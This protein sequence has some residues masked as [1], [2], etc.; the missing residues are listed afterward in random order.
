M[1]N[2]ASV[3]AGLDS[4]QRAMTLLK[5]EAQTLPL[6]GRLK[7]FVKNIDPA[8]ATRYAE[9]VDAPEQA[10]I[11]ILRLDTPWVPVK[12]K[13][14]FAQGFHHGDL[15]FKDKARAEILT[16]CKTVPTIVALYLDP[17]IGAAAKA[18]IGEYGASDT[19]VL[20][21]VFGK[22]GPEGKLPFELPDSMEAVRNQKSD[23]P[24]DS[25]NPLYPFGFGLSY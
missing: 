11:A 5:N 18:L 15:D 13:N 1:G 12:T 3:A 22:A 20:N 4:Q 24:Y 10:D 2:S 14:P 9:V 19:A 25:E 6:K 7:I 23:L 17:E 8:V 21:V 16:L